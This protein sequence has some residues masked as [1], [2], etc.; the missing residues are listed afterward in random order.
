[1]NQKKPRSDS[2]IAALAPELRAE[3]ARRL[4]EGNQSY[5]AVSSWLLED[6]HR[7]SVT[8]LCNWYSVHSW[9]EH[10]G[11]AREVAEAVRAEA[12]TSGDYD[13]ATLALVKER[14]YILARTK[15]ADVKDLATLAGIVG[16]SAKLRLKEREVAI[17]ERRIALLETRA[18]QADKAEGITRDETLTP[19]QRAAKLREIFGL[20]A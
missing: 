15:G 20:R 18:A 10:K 7:I 12:A 17:N 3:I 1:M 9:K 14:A 11:S 2:K 19:E 4:G 13:E 6:G 16:D 5:E 8:A